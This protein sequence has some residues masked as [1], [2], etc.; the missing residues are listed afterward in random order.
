MEKEQENSINE[1]EVKKFGDLAKEWWNPSGSF[2]TLHQINF[3]RVGYVVDVVR[4][5][6]EDIKGIT[7]LDVGCGGGL[8]CEPLARLGAIVDGIDAS[9]KNI[10]IAKE[11]AKESG[12]KI[13][14]CCSTIEK[15][16]NQYDVVTCLEVLEH[17]EQVDYFIKNCCDAV[18]KDGLIFFSTINRSVKSYLQTILGAEYILKWLPV[19]THEWAKF[20]KPSELYEQ[21]ENNK[22]KVCEIK[23]IKYNPLK[24]SSWYLDENIDVNYILYAKKL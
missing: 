21:I 22:F 20:I 11:H 13:K 4:K 12:L 10:T 2:K 16:K 1:D 14:Y 17:V 18:K 8:L 7:V 6:H 24:S 9:E 3:I 15:N 23:G 19:G 5:Y